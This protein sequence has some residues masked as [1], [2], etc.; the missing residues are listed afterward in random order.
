[1]RFLVRTILFLFVLVGG[2]NLWVVTNVPPTEDVLAL[3]L[4]DSQSLVVMG[5]DQGKGNVL[6]I[7]P[8]LRPIHFANKNTFRASLEVYFKWAK[9]NKL[10]TPSTIV[11]FPESLGTWLMAYEEKQDLYE[12]SQTN[13]ALQQLVRA[14]L[15]KF[16]WAYV[17]APADTK[18][19]YHYA[20]HTMSAAQVSSVY[21]DVLGGLAKAY[22]VTIVGGSIVLPNPTVDTSGQLVISKGPLYNTTVVFGPNGKVQGPLIKKNFPTAPSAG[23]VSPGHLPENPVIHTPAGKLGV[24]MGEDSWHPESYRLLQQKAKVLVVPALGGNEANWNEPWKGYD[25]PSVPGDLDRSDYQKISAG[26][27]WVKYG[28]GTRAKSAGIPMG[29]TLFFSGQIWGEQFSGRALV[30][31]GDSL[32]VLPPA[33]KGRMLSLW[34]PGEKSK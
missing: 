33:P 11:V 4:V 20:I 21:A 34:I 24:L 16:S 23:Y 6:G 8:F 26:Q 30:L 9:V 31:T 29:L 25:S 15:F 17:S 27:A 13:T 28:M 3:P 22:G 19:R 12:Q 10:L 14:N 1:M 7:Q 2:Y 32:Q 18:D 5:Q